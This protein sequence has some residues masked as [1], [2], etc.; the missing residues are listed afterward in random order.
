MLP[1]A[2]EQRSCLMKILLKFSCSNLLWLRV[3]CFK[4]NISQIVKK[5]YFGISVID[6]IFILVWENILHHFCITREGRRWHFFSISGVKQK[7]VSQFFSFSQV[8]LS[9]YFFLTPP[10]APPHIPPLPRAS[11]LPS[12]LM[13]MS[14]DEFLGS[15]LGVYQ[16][17]TFILCCIPSGPHLKVSLR[18]SVS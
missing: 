11:P 18:S 12:M 15:V 4:I 5:G 16:D 17:L 1:P 6:K 14:W 13:L 7:C 10:L 8:V 3:C 9:L 2:T